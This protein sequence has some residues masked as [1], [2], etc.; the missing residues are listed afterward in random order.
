MGQS[1]RGE[2]K[3]GMAELQWEDPGGR[4]GVRGSVACRS[5][6][7]PNKSRTAFLPDTTTFASVT[8]TSGPGTINGEAT[9]RRLLA[10][11]RGE[12]DQSC[13][14]TD[15][16]LGQ[17][18][19]SHFEHAVSRVFE[20]GQQSMRRGSTLVAHLGIIRSTR[21]RVLCDPLSWANRLSCA[22]HVDCVSFSATSHHCF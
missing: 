2:S 14:A 3:A 8:G 22:R 7:G 5:R 16:R 20:P 12:Q 4:P 10:S 11:R 9:S 15:S 1:V 18:L 21:F 19:A 6:P 13:T 17:V